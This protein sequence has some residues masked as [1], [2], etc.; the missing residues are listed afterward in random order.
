MIEDFSEQERPE[1]SETA[2][3]K[4]VS[5][6]ARREHSQSEL[7]WKLSSKGYDEIEVE[8]ALERLIEQGLQSDERF[9]EA[10][11]QAR[12]QRG[13]GPYKISMELNQKGVDESTAEQALNL[14]KFDWFE[15]AQSVYEKKYRGKVFSDYKEKAKRS[16]FMQSRGF[17][18]EQI[19]YAINGE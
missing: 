13:H 3:Q 9:A 11:V 14:K 17:S 1:H 15:L 7:R 12:Y 10:F 6:L 19:S 8:E 4:A 2:L 18:S 5:Y 16:R